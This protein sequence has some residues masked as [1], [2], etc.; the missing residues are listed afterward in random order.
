MKILD[1]LFGLPLEY[2]TL[3]LTTYN[4]KAA[5]SIRLAMIFALLTTWILTAFILVR[6]SVFYIS[7]WATTFLFAALLMVALASG[8]QVVEGK[9]KK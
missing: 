8:R 1:Y 4:F 7:F 3:A 9:M 6:V 5:Q 2:N